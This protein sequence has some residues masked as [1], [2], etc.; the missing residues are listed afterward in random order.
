MQCGMNGHRAA[1]IIADA[2]NKKCISSLHMSRNLIRTKANRWFLSLG[3]ANNNGVFAFF[4]GERKL[5]LPGHVT[6]WL[7]RV[8]VCVCRWNRS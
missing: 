2:D 5:V 3:V 7:M 4:V 8:F 1:A 6:P